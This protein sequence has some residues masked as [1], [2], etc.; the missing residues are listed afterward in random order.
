MIIGIDFDNT[1]VCYDRLFHKLALKRGLIP[2][3]CPRVK[4]KIRDFL[5]KSGKE[6]DWTELQGRAYGP[7]ILKAKPFR[8]VR[9]F[10]GF[11]RKHGIEV[12]V[13]S[14]K[15]LYPFIGEKHNL[16]MYAR[17]WLKKNGFMNGR[18]GLPEKN[19]FF[20]LLKQDKLER[21]RKQKC[22]VYIDD[23]W[24]FLSE[25]SFPDKAGKVLFDPSG[26]FSGA[27][28][29]DVVHSWKGAI[30]LVSEKLMGVQSN[31]V[32]SLGKRAKL[33]ASFMLNSVVSGGRNNRAYELSYGRKKA[34]LK[35]YFSH[36]DDGRNRL[37]AEYYFL[38]FA[39][40]KGIHCVPKPYAADFGRNIGLYQYIE[41]RKP[42]KSEIDWEKIKTALDFFSRLNRG[43]KES[44]AEK[45]PLASEACFSINEHLDC[46]G[47]RLERLKNAKAESA[48]D[49]L[50]FGFV[51][52]RLAAAWDMAALHARKTAEKHGIFM[53]KRIP[54]E[55]TCISP[56]DFGF[57][58]AIIGRNGKVYFVD[59]EYAGLD[60]PAKLVCDFFCQP[61]MPVPLEYSREFTEMISSIAPGRSGDIKNRINALF[62]AYRVKW[63]CIML[64]D[65]LD[66]G[67]KRREFAGRQE[68]IEK[69]KDAQL[70]KAKRYLSSSFEIF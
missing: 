52:K 4:E 16:H 43:K 22:D 54:D 42:E 56:S 38:E 15:T 57:H 7:D 40:K 35:V 51:D 26:N 34:L 61:E 17:L 67:S 55:E 24:E 28:E 65:F 44:Y 30:S 21:I 14:H 27:P 29:F 6:G 68:D 47:R 19:V 8:G 3:S 33:P 45:M 12:Y 70:S 20:E 62:P 39:R 49:R 59:F 23:L 25:K 18:I 36:P 1:I 48:I 10:L 64:N 53:E 9:D 2:K 13:I 58:N 32:S 37:R 5:R 31:A 60:D 46:I 41:G 69:R 11:C 66:A 63:C 50:A